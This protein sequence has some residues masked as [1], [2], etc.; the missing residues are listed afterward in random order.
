[1]VD[2]DLFEQATL[3]SVAQLSSIDCSLKLSDVYDKITF[4]P[5]YRVTR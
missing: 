2:F 1:M 3:D 4:V 5:N